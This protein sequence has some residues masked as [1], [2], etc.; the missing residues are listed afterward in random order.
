MGDGAGTT[1]IEDDLELQAVRAQAD[2]IRSKATTIAVV[3]ALLVLV[4]P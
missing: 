2:E 4:L 1:T 3:T